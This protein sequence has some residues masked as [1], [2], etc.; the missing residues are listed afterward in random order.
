MRGSFR[1][2]R[3][4]LG[5]RQSLADDSR[6]Q[7]SRRPRQRRLQ[8]RRPRLLPRRRHRGLQRPR[9]QPGRRR[10]PRQARCP[11]RC[12]RSTHND[13]AGFWWT[14]SLNTF[15]RNV[16]AECDQ[17]GFRYEAT[18]S[19][20][21]KLTFPILQPDGTQQGHGHPHAAVRPLRGQ[22]SPQQSRPVR[23]QPRRGRQPRR[24]GRASTR[25][26]SATSRSGTCTTASARRC[27]I[28]AGREPDD[29]QGRP[30]ASITRTT[31]TTSTATCSSARRTPSRS[32]A[33]TTT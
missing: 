22:R 21:L 25:S 12:C 20:A 8:E 15:T 27:R 1:H 32:T 14:N 30:T 23:R 17:Y 29:P 5:Q 13:G 10:S 28:A 33:A 3:L 4:D 6:H 18:P 24:P 26:S 9:P 19:S 16:A 31:T 2:R 11:S 7:L